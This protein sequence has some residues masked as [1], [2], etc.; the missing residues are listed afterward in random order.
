MQ[1]FADFLKCIWKTRHFVREVN[2]TARWR[3]TAGT[4]QKQTWAATAMLA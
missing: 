3:F 4:F 1:G 2:P